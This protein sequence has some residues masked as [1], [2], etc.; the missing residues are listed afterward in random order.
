[1]V[2]IPKPNKPNYSVPKAYQPIQLLEKLGKLLER[3]FAKQLMFDC[4]CFDLIPA[5]QFGGVA[6]ASCVDTGLSLTHDIKH[7]LYC[8]LTASLLTVDIKGFF[9]NINHSRLT[10]ILYQMGFP[11]LIVKW[12]SSFLLDRTV[13]MCIGSHTGLMTPIN[14]GVP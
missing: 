6:L 2:V 9:D 13:T 5:C 10:Y 1:M 11:K 14:M 4:S 8:N 12:V 7:A 3:V